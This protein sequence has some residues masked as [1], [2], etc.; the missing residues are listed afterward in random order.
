ME[1]KCFNGKV[2]RTF[3]QLKS[4]AAN[5]SL[6]AGI[7]RIQG[8]NLSSH[9]VF[10]CSN[11]TVETLEQ[12]FKCLKLT[13]KIPERCLFKGNNKDTKTKPLVSFWCIYC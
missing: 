6:D 5:F 8:V 13:I 11:L 3:Q 9:P 10:T 1:V 7:L 4:M 2:F 12:D